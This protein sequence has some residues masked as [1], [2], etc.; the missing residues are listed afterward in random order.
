MLAGIRWDRTGCK[1]D[2][3]DMYN[4]FPRL[5]DPEDDFFCAD[6]HITEEVCNIAQEGIILAFEELNV[7]IEWCSGCH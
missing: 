4:H 1:V 3:K 6:P 2:I 7:P 5:S